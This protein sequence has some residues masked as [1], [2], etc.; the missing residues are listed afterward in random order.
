[1]IVADGFY[2]LIELAEPCIFHALNPLGDIVTLTRG[3]AGR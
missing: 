1:M 2:G 3:L